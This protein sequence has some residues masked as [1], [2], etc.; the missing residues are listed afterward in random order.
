MSVVRS[1]VDRHQTLASVLVLAVPNLVMWAILFPGYLQADHQVLI[2]RIAEGELNQHHSLVWGLFAF[3]FLYLTPS[4]GVYGLVQILLFVAAALYSARKLVRLGVLRSTF[5]LCA[6]MGLFPTYLLYNE[7]YCSDLCFAYVL[8]VLTVSLVELVVTRGDALGGWGFCLRVVVL[9][10]I[11]FNLR[12]NAV[13]IP[14]F[15]LVAVPLAYRQK[16]LRSIAVF[17]VAL[18]VS[19][20]VDSFFPLVL[21]AKRSAS[22]EMIGI[23]AFQIAYVYSAGGDIP[24]EA[25]AELT[26]TRTAEEWAEAYIPYSSDFA[27]MDMALTPEFVRSWLAVG[28][29]N[30]QAYLYAYVQLI[31]PFWTLG[32]E[33]MDWQN[34]GFVDIDFGNYDDFTTTNFTKLRDGYVGQFGTWESA[35]R[36]V[37]KD[38]YAN[39][40]RWRVPV[41]SDVCR[42]VL[43]DRGPP[44]WLLVA[45]FVITRRGSR[46]AYFLVSIP[47]FAIVFSLLI[48][49]VMPMF[50]YVVPVYFA[51]PYLGAFFWHLRGH[52]GRLEGG[53]DDGRQIGGR[54][55]HGGRRGDLAH[56]RHFA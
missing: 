3:P 21:H 49:A 47:M 11:A 41:L 48:A 55:E 12:K 8:M 31:S 32:Y 28:V 35:A 53:E 2:G 27:K 23:P 16:A 39:I 25:N 33:D 5:P 54:E 30:P 34:Q 10:V 51:L 15:L 14:L 38:L 4:F 26:K 17:G 36:N 42:L 7:L 1:W 13:L 56:A 24:A 43:F 46:G 18:V 50:R 29:R 6:F 40:V 19:V 44:L 20:C 9:V 45:G 22:S 52:G 37:P